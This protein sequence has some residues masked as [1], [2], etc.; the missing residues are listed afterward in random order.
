MTWC[1]P[2]GRAAVPP[3]QRPCP[4]RGRP[5]RRPVRTRAAHRRSRSYAP[6]CASRAA[7]AR[8]PPLGDRG[9]RRVQQAEHPPS[10]VNVPHSCRAENSACPF[11]RPLRTALT[12]DSYVGQTF[13]R[14][15]TFLRHARGCAY[16]PS[17][18][19]RARDERSR[20]G[21]TGD[22]LQVGPAGGQPPEV[23]RRV[24]RQAI[25]HCLRTT[26]A[27]PS[28]MARLLQRHHACPGPGW[29]NRHLRRTWNSPLAHTARNSL[30]CA[31]IV[32]S[33]SDGMAQKSGIPRSRTVRTHW[34][35]CPGVRRPTP[36]AFGHPAGGT[37]FGR[38]P[39]GAHGAHSTGACAGACSDRANGTDGGDTTD[40]D[41]RQIRKTSGTSV[42]L[43]GAR[44]GRG[45]PDT[46][47]PATARVCHVFG[48]TITVPGTGAGLP[49]PDKNS[50][51]AKKYRN[52]TCRG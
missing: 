43:P 28:P 2:D 7:S 52:K 33:S 37:D 38:I 23:E 46:D 15:R 22:S 4:D 13:E 16:P 25:A 1:T 39:T 9:T 18:A 31:E 3:G 49:R 30:T 8:I 41:H 14:G 45:R 19:G 50:K 35:A 40:G 6:P 20:P 36:R 44:G 29:L 17:G 42:E 47:R 51:T 21:R 48:C 5:G 32:R 27:N 26:R 11:L 24:Y 10:P 34:E 12:Y